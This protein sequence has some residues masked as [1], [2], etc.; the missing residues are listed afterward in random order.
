MK[1]EL[2]PLVAWTDPETRPRQPSRFTANWSATLALLER[3][4]KL[5]NTKVVVIQLDVTE[6]DIRRDGMVYARAR[7]DHPG[8][9]VSF[10]SKYG[11]LR[12]ATDTYRDGGS[13]YTPGWQANV[14]AIAL[15]IEALRA[16]DRY[17]VSKRGEQF[18]GWRAISA[19]VEGF[20]TAD[21]A[22]RWMREKA[23]NGNAADLWPRPLYRLL[24]KQ[25]HPDSGG[26]RADWDRLD[27]ARQLLDSAGW[28]L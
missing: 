17:G 4:T 9:V 14:R 8:V 6:R 27:Q 26:D 13:G 20:A 2:R 11:P 24:A 19:P 1:F 12:Y 5:L 18:T 21:E 10:D 28:Q 22:V 7:P 15:S 3:E 23:G 25:L 16:V